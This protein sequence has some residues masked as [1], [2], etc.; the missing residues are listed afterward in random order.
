MSRLLDRAPWTALGLLWPF[1]GPPQPEVAVGPGASFRVVASNALKTNHRAAA[2]SDAVLA[3]EPDVL[4][5]AELT[6]RLE[7]ALS[8]AGPPPHR[9]AAARRGSDGTGL[10]S[11]WPIEDAE[12]LQ[13]GRALVV[14]RIPGVGATVGAVHT[15]A[16]SSP[17][18]TRGWWQSFDAVQ[19]LAAR[20][21][22]PLVV[23]GDWNATMGHSPLRRLVAGGRL[24]DAHTDAGR[25]LARTWPARF[26]VALL[27]RVLVSPGIAVRRITEHRVP[28]SDHRAI[29]ADL[30]VVG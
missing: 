1:G 29:A 19:A 4:C 16:P 17:W 20:T 8:A 28:G 18:R 30:V 26:P 6:P 10:W 3:L 9:C 7:R 12:V 22:G 13:A 21:Q 15:V 2:W 24:R 11:R 25:R 5:V 27:D 23:A 14:A